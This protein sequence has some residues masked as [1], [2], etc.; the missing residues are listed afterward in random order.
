[1]HE[2]CHR[3]GG[4]LSAGPEETLFCSHCGAPQ[5]YLQEQDR[6]EPLGEPSTT[7]ALPP[8]NP[9]QV[10]WKTAIRCAALVAGVAAV[11]SLAATRIPVLSPLST[12]WILTGSMTTLA[13]YQRQRPLAWMDAAVGARIGIMAGLVLVAFVSCAMAVAG[14]VAR[15]GLHTMETFDAELAQQLHAQIEHTSQT[16]PIPPDILHYFYTPEF[17]AGMMLTGVAMMASFVLIFSTL[18]GA[19]SGMLRMR[20][21]THA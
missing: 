3:C 20:R 2:T 8:P 1:M 15:F 4:V 21:Q 18:G 16:N 13:L 7:G 11:L 14:L 5:L 10:E 9:Q 6:P 17:R 19:V 12:L